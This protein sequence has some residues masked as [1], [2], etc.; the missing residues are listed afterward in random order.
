VHCFG[1][2]FWLA[3][4]TNRPTRAPN[5]LEIGHLRRLATALRGTATLSPPVQR[6]RAT[7]KSQKGAKRGEPLFTLFPSQTGL[8]ISSNL[9]SITPTCCPF[10]IGPRA[11]CHFW[12]PLRPLLN[13]P[14]GHKEQGFKAPTLSSNWATASLQSSSQ[15]GRQ[16]SARRR[17]RSSIIFGQTFATWAPLRTGN[18]LLCT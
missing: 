2:L 4:S 5:E 7:P 13:V 8:S 3:E 11:L 14:N 6:R 1:L 9:C 16:M 12:P 15:I 10:R 18:H 17:P